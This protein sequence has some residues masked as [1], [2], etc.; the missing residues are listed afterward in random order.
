MRKLVLAFLLAASTLHRKHR[1]TDWYRAFA[2]F[3]TLVT[4]GLIALY[5]LQHT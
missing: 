3:S 2:I 5:L 4:I 1:R